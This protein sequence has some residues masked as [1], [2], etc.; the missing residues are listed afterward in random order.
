MQTFEPT[1]TSQVDVFLRELLRSSR[2]D[3]HAN[4]SFSCYR[5]AGDIICQLAFGYPLNTQTEPTNRLFLDAMGAIN[6]RVSL[7][8]SWPATSVVLDPLVKW[9]GKKRVAEFRKFVFAMIHARTAMEKDAQ[10][11]LYAIALRDTAGDGGSDEGL[12]ESELWANATFFIN[13]VKIPIAVLATALGKLT[14]M[15]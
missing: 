4:M 3:E 7:Y 15:P 2:N 12:H 14:P 8:M 10:H 1:M 9:L 5:L 11:D 13:V 6:S